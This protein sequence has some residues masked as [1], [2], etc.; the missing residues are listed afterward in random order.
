MSFV[1]PYGIVYSAFVDPSGGRHD[2]YTLAIAHRG[3]AKRIIVDRVEEVSAPFDPKTV[4]AEFCEIIKLYR[5]HR[6]HGDKYSGNWVSSTFKDHEIQYISTDQPKSELYLS[7]QALVSMRQVQIPDNDRLFQQLMSLER[8]TRSGGRDSVD[9]PPGMHDDLANAVA[10]VCATA[11]SSRVITMEEQRSFLPVKIPR[12]QNRRNRIKD[13]AQE[14][15]E[16]MLSSGCNKIV[17]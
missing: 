14:M 2:S 16:Y 12:N 4:T 6:V 13:V 11:Y 8:R 10:G 17:R 3:D 1:K 9:H 7:L 15:E 5:I